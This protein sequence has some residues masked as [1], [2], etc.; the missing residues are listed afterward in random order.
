MAT[1]HVPEPIRAQLKD[2]EGALRNALHSAEV[3]DLDDLAR[4]ILVMVN[5]CKGLLELPD[6]DPGIV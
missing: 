2:A 4:Q 6:R 3:N 5:R 1:T